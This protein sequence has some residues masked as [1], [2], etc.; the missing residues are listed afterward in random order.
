MSVSGPGFTP[1]WS[2]FFGI[3]L[4]WEVQKSELDSNGQQLDLDS[5]R[6]PV[7]STKSYT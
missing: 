3:G 7:E 1:V 5:E 6:I 2:R 4:D